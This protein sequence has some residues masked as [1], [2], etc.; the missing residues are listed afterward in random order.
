MSYFSFII[1]NEWLFF[2]VPV[3]LVSSI[4]YFVRS[5]PIKVLKWYFFILFGFMAF[6]AILRAWFQYITWLSGPPG[7]YFL[8]PYQPISYFWQYSFTHHLATFLLTIAS[9]L[10]AA[11]LFL[12]FKKWRETL[13][14]K[15]WG[16][17]EEYIFFS[18]A[19][20]LRWPLVIPYI[21]LGIFFAMIFFLFRI[22]VLKSQDQAID[23]MP[24]FAG[25]VLPMLYLK[26]V[27]LYGFL[28]YPLLMPF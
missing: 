12:L 14:R 28:L 16:E 2:F 8:P 18:G 17:G 23:V 4:L 26:E 27:I 10:V 6:R 19:F 1:G 11:G 22:Y 5:I 20:L 9:V 24:F 13:D 3:Y 21:F 7:I 15:L 25:L